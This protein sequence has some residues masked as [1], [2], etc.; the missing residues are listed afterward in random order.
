M[1][2]DLPDKVQVQD[3]D[4]DMDKDILV[5]KIL[6]AAAAAAGLLVSP[7]L[8]VSRPAD[9]HLS[10]TFTLDLKDHQSRIVH[11][12]PSR[13][14]A[15]VE[16]GRY[17]PLR[18]DS[19]SQ[20]LAVRVLEVWAWDRI[21]VWAW[22]KEWAWDKGWVWGSKWAWAWVW[23][24][25]AWAWVVV[26][27]VWVVA[28]VVV[29]RDQDPTP[30]HHR[31]SRWPGIVRDLRMASAGRKV[32]RARARDRG[33]GIMPAAAAAAAVVSRGTRRTGWE[34]KRRGLGKVRGCLTSRPGRPLGRPLGIP[35]GVCPQIDEYS[36]RVPKACQ[37]ELLAREVEFHVTDVRVCAR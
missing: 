36:A 33:R 3:K 21:W 31:R 13:S 19:S 34:E 23:V 8:T 27:W 10:A 4:K 16:A 30:R 15:E 25:V 22:D 24:V 20:E 29:R 28:L 32:G 18:W 2:G 17:L 14:E 35:V 12:R 6:T 11:H 1:A 9:P 37:V 26:V 7:H 5:C